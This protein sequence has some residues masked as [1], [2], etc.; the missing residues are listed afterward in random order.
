MFLTYS[1]NQQDYFQERLE[2]RL[3]IWDIYFDIYKADN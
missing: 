3:K 1:I 2:N